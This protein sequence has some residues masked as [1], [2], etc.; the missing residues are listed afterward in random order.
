MGILV[1][2]RQSPRRQTW[3][4]SGENQAKAV[5]T[6]PM[7]HFKVISKNYSLILIIQK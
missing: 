5:E 3:S 6:S 7:K 1:A 4:G 2:E